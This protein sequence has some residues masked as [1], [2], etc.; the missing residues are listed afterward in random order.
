MNRLYGRMS[1]F[2]TF[3]FQ[4]ILHISLYFSR[5]LNTNQLYSHPNEGIYD[6]HSDYNLAFNKNDVQQRRQ[7]GL[8]DKHP[9]HEA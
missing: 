9:L 7:S 6:R 8:P 2:Q 4:N 3:I 1:C 5:I